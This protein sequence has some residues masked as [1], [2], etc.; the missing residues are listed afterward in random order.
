MPDGHPPGKR[1]KRT[2][3]A[4]RSAV[5]LLSTEAPERDFVVSRGWRMIIA[6]DPASSFGV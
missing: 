4:R 3:V 1:M 6:D 5:L 2:A